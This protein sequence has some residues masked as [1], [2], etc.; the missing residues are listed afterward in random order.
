MKFLK[1]IVLQKQLAFITTLCSGA[2][3]KS[4]SFN[5]YYY[6]FSINMS[7]LKDWISSITD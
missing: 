5:K 1:K 2:F 4:L 3:L 6:F 7:L